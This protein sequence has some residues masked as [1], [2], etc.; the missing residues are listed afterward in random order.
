MPQ[1]GK[2][3]KKATELEVINT[4]FS[5]GPLIS[6]RKINLSPTMWFAKSIR[7]ITRYAKFQINLR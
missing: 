6:E 4:F 2:N 7:K 3:L 1:I 5:F